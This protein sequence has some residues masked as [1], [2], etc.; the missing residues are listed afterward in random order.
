MRKERLGII[1]LFVVSLIWGVAFLAVD[2]ALE[3]NWNTFT[4]LTIRGVLSGLILFPFVLKDKMWKHKKLFI[5][6][7]IAG[8]FFFLGYASQTLGQQKSSVINTAFYTCLYV[9]FTPFLALFFGKKEVTIKTFIASICAILGVYFLSVLGNGGKFEFYIG[10]LFLISCAIFFA[11]QIIW[12]G[13]FIKDEVSP[14]SISSIMLLT[15]GV[16]SLISIPLFNETLPPSFKGITGVLFATLFS[17]GLCSILQLYGQRHV[18]SSNASIIL[19][20]ET[21]IACILAIVVNKEH[22]NL[23]MTIG[24]LLMIMIT[25]FFTT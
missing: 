7:M 2:Y 8:A 5:N 17:S 6:T 23:Y 4:I 21:P 13:H 10:D 9:V 22:I 15:M 14:I 19:S 25:M 12:A 24:L 16:L 20:M 11:L 1:S 3:N 18:P